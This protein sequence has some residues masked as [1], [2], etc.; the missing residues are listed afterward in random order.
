MNK[1]SRYSHVFFIRLVGLLFLLSACSTTRQTNYFQD[2]YPGESEQKVLFPLEIKV[3]PDD[4]I[5]IMVS[6]RDPQL[7]SLFNLSIMS[8]QGS[9]GSSRGLS[10]YMVDAQGE[11]DFPVLGKIHIAGKKRSEIAAFIK[12]EL[13]SGNYVK[14]PVVT[15]EFMNLTISVLGEVNHPGRFNIDRNQM[16][17]LDAIGMAGDLTIYGRR[18]KVLVLREENGTQRTYGI[19][20]CSASQMYSSPA[21]NLQQNDVIYVEPNTVRA[22]QSTVN[23]NNVR[24]TSFWISLASLLTTISVLVFK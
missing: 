12:N 14:D 17:L 13:I 2:L 18:D 5:S 3:Q 15:V 7:T 10:G 19:N 6:S 21:Y 1:S 24:S 23:G 16:T 8:Q 4:Q 9:S 20:L 11:I 22:R